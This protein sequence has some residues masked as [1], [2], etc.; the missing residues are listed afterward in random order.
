MGEALLTFL[1]PHQRPPTLHTAVAVRHRPVNEIQVD[2]V[3]PVARRKRGGNSGGGSSQVPKPSR[4]MWKLSFKGDMG[5]V[6]CI[7]LAEAL[8]RVHLRE[9]ANWGTFSLGWVS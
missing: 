6:I 5:G 7:L 1:Q 4:G 9:I 8:S 2:I 3:Q